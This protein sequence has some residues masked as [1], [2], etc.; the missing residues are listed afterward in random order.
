MKPESFY[1]LLTGEDSKVT[2]VVFKGESSDEPRC[3]S[4][5]NNGFREGFQVLYKPDL[6]NP[7][8]FRS[9]S[10]TWRDGGHRRVTNLE[11]L[12]LYNYGDIE[13]YA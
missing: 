8:F 10:V 13:M 4:S 7:R 11:E 6:L 5:I 12:V 9:G 3:T 2:S 1:Y